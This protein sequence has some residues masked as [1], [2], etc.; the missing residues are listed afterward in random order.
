M[1][2]VSFSL[3]GGRNLNM[4][5]PYFADGYWRYF[6]LDFNNL[7]PMKHALTKLQKKTLV[8]NSLMIRKHCIQR[9]LRRIGID[10]GDKQE[11]IIDTFESTIT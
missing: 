1:N 7:M 2:G 6:Q 3:E 4:R 9:L 8:M 11:P 5:M 10:S